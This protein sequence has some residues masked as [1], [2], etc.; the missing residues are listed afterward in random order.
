MVICDMFLVVWCSYGEFWPGAGVSW[1]GAVVLFVYSIATGPLEYLRMVHCVI[2]SSDIMCF[3][4]FFVVIIA[5]AR[6]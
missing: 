6:F 5:S 1:C 2:D 4:V 3:A